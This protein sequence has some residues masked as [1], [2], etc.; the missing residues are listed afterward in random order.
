MV[1]SG[2]VYNSSAIHRFKK[3]QG[4]DRCFPLLLLD[5]ASHFFERLRTPAHCCGVV[6]ALIFAGFALGLPVRRHARRGQYQPPP[7][8]AGFP[9]VLA[10]LQ[11][12]SGRLSTR[13]TSAVEA[14]RR[15]GRRLATPALHEPRSLRSAQQ[16]SGI[17]RHWRVRAE[18]KR[19][20]LLSSDRRCACTV[21]R[22]ETGRH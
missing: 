17:Q 15:D 2:Q 9:A 19:D 8:A 1:S 14:R 13:L 6:V 11:P 20:M 10:G 12:H 5:R 18:R 4:F 16:R 7:E 21:G 22:D 3:R